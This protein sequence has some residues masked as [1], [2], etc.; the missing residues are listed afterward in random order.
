MRQLF[1]ELALNAEPLSGIGITESLSDSSEPE[2][3]T[4]WRLQ[5]AL[6]GAL[7]PR[8]TYINI[9][10]L[11]HESTIRCHTLGGKVFNLHFAVRPEGSAIGLTTDSS[12]S[13]MNPEQSA[14]FIVKP[15]VDW[16]RSRASKIY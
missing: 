4:R 1:R 14:Q 13:L 11:I 5:V 9:F 7:V 6:T 3:E 2:F 15:M 12:L 8:F 10:H 16:I